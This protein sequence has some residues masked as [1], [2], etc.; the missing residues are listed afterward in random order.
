MWKKLLGSLVLVISILS[1]GCPNCPLSDI[2][3][4]KS[5]VIVQQLRL[6][7]IWHIGKGCNLW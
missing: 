4:N 7:Q 3:S 1:G 2:E 6:K 5:P